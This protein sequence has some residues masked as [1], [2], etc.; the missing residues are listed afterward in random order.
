ML[1]V[2]ARNLLPKAANSMGR[3]ET[4]SLHTAIAMLSRKAG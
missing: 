3:Y 4:P 2:L 1:K